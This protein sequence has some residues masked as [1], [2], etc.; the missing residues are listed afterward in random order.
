MRNVRLVFGRNGKW[1][2][3]FLLLGPYIQ[4]TQVVLSLYNLIALTFAYIGTPSTNKTDGRVIISER[5]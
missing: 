1:T 2:T 3:L 5:A 4:L